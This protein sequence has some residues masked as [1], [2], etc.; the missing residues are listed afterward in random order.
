[1][2]KSL[3]FSL[4]TPYGLVGLSFNCTFLAL[5]YPTISVFH[6]ES[7]KKWRTVTERTEKVRD[8]DTHSEIKR[9][10]D[11]GILG[12]VGGLFIESKDLCA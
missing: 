11:C 5:C 10:R 7:L 4:L 1:M 9:E 6:H 2:K 3:T 12:W 8:R